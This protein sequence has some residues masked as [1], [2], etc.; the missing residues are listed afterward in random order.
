MSVR[1]LA[2]AYVAACG[3][4]KCFITDTDPRKSYADLLGGVQTVFGAGDARTAAFT[5]R[6][7]SYGVDQ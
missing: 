1:D 3:G 5:L 4:R 6:A 2:K 7:L